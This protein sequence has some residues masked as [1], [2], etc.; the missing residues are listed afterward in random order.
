MKYIIIGVLVVIGISLLS[1]FSKKK[2]LSVE[3]EIDGKGL[4]KQNVSFPEKTKTESK[5][6]IK[7]GKEESYD[8]SWFLNKNNKFK[9]PKYHSTK[10]FLVKI[11]DVTDYQEYW[12]ES[13]SDIKR[14]YDIEKLENEIFYGSLDIIF[15]IDDDEGMDFWGFMDRLNVKNL[16]PY[17]ILKDN[18]SIFM[19]ILESN[20]KYIFPDDEFY[21]LLFQN[22][23]L[24][25]YEF[26]DND[27]RNE[28]IEKYKNNLRNLNVK[29]LKELSKKRGLKVSL[30]KQ[31]LINQLL[32]YNDF[33]DISNP[34]LINDKFK[35]MVNHFLDLYLN[36]IRN[37]IDTFHP[38]YIQEIWKELQDNEWCEK[39]NNKV[40]KEIYDSKYWED[41]MYTDVISVS[42]FMRKQYG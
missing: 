15:E 32:E 21:H 3:S 14:N 25:Q 9:F 17:E 10:D 38:L 29:Q 27:K 1:R 23:F 4:N 13:D 35:E 26:K 7:R 34:Y 6:E 30:K 2:T 8:K 18:I 11:K 33:N 36:N 31:E 20:D 12:R 22:G 28:Y 39:F 5:F 42:E 24:S 16:K 41:R 40:Y 19:E 37:Q